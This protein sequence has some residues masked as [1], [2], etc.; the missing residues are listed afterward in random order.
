LQAAGAQ[1]PGRLE[2]M[3]PFP[4]GFGVLLVLVA[5]QRLAE[6]RVSR[7]NLRHLSPQATSAD[8]GGTFGWMVVLHTGLVVLPVIEVLF[9][10]H[11]ASGAVFWA[12]VAVFFCAEGLRYWALASLGRLWN[13]RAVVD[14]GQDVVVR[15]PYRF[16]RHPNYLAVV[17]EFLAVPAAGGA[18]VSLAILNLLH[19]P[20]LAARIR[21]EEA[22][23][24]QLPGYR[25]SM[26]DKGRLLPRPGSLRPGGGSPRKR[27][28]D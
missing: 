16:L 8:P 10:G 1:E 14:P 6:L 22:L 17:L 4:P 24:F 2:A 21:S 3:S 25:E 15:G 28:S 11:G 7:R 12:A 9:R 23:L 13:V 5:L 27:P 19:L 18:W 20:V 26:G